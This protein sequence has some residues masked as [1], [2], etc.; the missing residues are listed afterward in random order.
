MSMRK[1]ILAIVLLL[2][3]CCGTCF[4]R[5]LVEP[6]TLT[7]KKTYSMD[8]RDKKDLYGFLSGWPSTDMGLEY[9]RFY[10]DR[11]RKEFRGR[12]WNV[13]FGNRIGDIFGDIYIVYRDGGFDLVFTNINAH[14]KYNFVHRLSTHDDRFNRT[15]YWRATHNAKLIDEIRKRSKEIFE[16]IT[17]SMDEYLKVGPPV[18]LKK[19]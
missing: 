16:M 1:V 6:D 14:W 18:E 17:A 3:E 4:G 13:A 7:F 19:L 9:S 8:G 5:K 2:V 11:D 12:F 15:W 10:H